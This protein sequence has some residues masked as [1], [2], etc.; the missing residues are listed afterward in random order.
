MQVDYIDDEPRD[1]PDHYWLLHGFD[2]HPEFVSHMS[3]MGA[4]IQCILS[5]MTPDDNDTNND[6]I[7][8]FENKETTPEINEISIS[9][10]DNGPSTNSSNSKS[11]K[12]TKP[13]PLT[14]AKVMITF[15]LNHAGILYFYLLH[16]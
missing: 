16:E 8:N 7:P 12:P 9:Y 1:G 15:S 11:T 2:T 5:L 13:A 3:T 6:G 4:N 10:E 14:E